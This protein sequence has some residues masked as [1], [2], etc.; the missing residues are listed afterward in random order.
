MARTDVP[1]PPTAD[2]STLLQRWSGGDLDARDALM[3][4]VYDE[5]R[6]RAAT[7][8]RR[9]RPTHTLQPTA[10]VH[11]AYV[12][13]VGQ[14]NAAWRNRAQ[15]FAVA[16]EIMRRILVDWARAHATAKRSGRW[17]RVTIDPEF[18]VI[19]P[20]DVDVIDLDAAL[21]EL[22]ALDRRKSRIAELRFFAGLSLEDTAAVLQVSAKTV[23]R[24]WQ[25]ARA[26]L[27]KALS[28]RSAG[29]GEPTGDD[30]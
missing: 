5:L 25:V 12:R 17:S 28:A 15:F 26:W 24:D 4:L 29:A 22:A 27:F 6:R 3:P 2:V 18:A 30:A 23:E 11:E 10:L 9:E 14:R 8:M 19:G 7:C 20:P 13:L 16:A 1:V 21:A